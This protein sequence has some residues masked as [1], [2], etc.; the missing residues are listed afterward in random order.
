MYE[1]TFQ[2][3]C[4]VIMEKGSV[5]WDDM[6]E[7]TFRE[8]DAYDRMKEVWN[9]KGQYFSLKDSPEIIVLDKDKNGMNIYGRREPGVVDEKK[10]LLF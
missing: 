8:P 4:K 7:I 1:F 5:C 3:A 6:E 9:G 10:G 2:Y